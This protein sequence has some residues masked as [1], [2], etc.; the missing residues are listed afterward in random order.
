MVS[1]VP[2]GGVPLELRLIRFGSMDKPT[3]TVSPLLAAERP[4]GLAEEFVRSAAYSGLQVPVNGIVQ[5]TD[6]AFAEPLLPLV[7][8]IEPPA[9]TEFGS[10]HWHA[11]QL[12]AAAGVILPFLVVHKGVSFTSKT[13]VNATGLELGRGAAR[14]LAVFELATTGAAFDGLLKPVDDTTKGAFIENRLR[15]AFTGGATMTTLGLSSLGLKSFGANVPGRLTGILRN[16]CAATAL[17]GVPAG[18]VHAETT[19]LLSK[20][21]HASIK[22]L[23]E[24]CYSFAVIGGGLGL[25]MRYARHSVTD[26]P[27]PREIAQTKSQIERLEQQ[28][29]RL[30]D[31][32]IELQQ[33]RKQ[34]QERNNS[35]DAE[36][37]D[38]AVER[39]DIEH[40]MKLLG[41]QTKQ[42]RADTIS[43]LEQSL[44][45]ARLA[46]RRGINSG[47]S[48][49]VLE[50]GLDH[51]KG[52]FPRTRGDAFF[53]KSARLGCQ[54]PLEV[55]DRVGA[56]VALDV[57][58]HAIESPERPSL[59]EFICDL[60]Q[61]FR[62]R[63]NSR[64]DG[65]VTLNFD[66]SDSR[67]PVYDHEMGHVVDLRH[68]DNNADIN[69][70]V[71]DA[72]QSDVNSSS[73]R[74]VVKD[75]LLQTDYVPPRQHQ[76]T[77]ADRVIPQHLRKDAYY[78]SR[79][80][81]IA[82]S[83]K[84][85]LR[86]KGLVEGGLRE[87]SFA[88]MLDQIVDNSARRARLSEFSGT[89]EVLKQRVFEPLYSA[90][91]QR[92]SGAEQN[93]A[94]Q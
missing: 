49:R 91:M 46:S 33:Q 79:A 35:L 26:P 51:A 78:S 74:Q 57:V 24:S 13:L 52:Y 37:P 20:G 23:R 25:G 12:G 50:M 73:H 9:K 2:A 44:N 94:R 90:E 30:L 34:L 70:A 93:G 75:V 48:V 11:Q 62:G 18:L 92:R 77:P 19:S 54:I 81:V 69:R 38:H 15:N 71:Q 22:E 40:Q 8:F 63:A 56:N 7:Q 16:E 14:G 58:S 88:E 89:Y 55:P 4:A 85:F 76:A 64:R 1:C 39:A 86:S 65:Q 3:L 31:Q 32:R 87:T 47:A 61:T 21:E 6:K 72:Y 82:E 27:S 60:N 66:D 53:I 68:I 36:N 28:R 83:Y 42:V 41:R 43:V 84:V 45:L 59:L 10:A 29:G 80:E 17:A 5:M 67:T